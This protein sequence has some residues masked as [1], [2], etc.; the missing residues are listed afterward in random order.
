LKETDGMKSCLD[1]VREVFMSN[2]YGRRNATHW[3]VLVPCVTFPQ[4]LRHSFLFFI[5][6]PPQ[7]WLRATS[8]CRFIGCRCWIWL[9]LYSNNLFWNNCLDFGIKNAE[10]KFTH[11]YICIAMSLSCAK[12][13]HFWRGGHWYIQ[14]RNQVQQIMPSLHKVN[15][16]MGAC[17][18]LHVWSAKVLMRFQWALI[19]W[20]YS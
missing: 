1:Q 17:V 11:S 15:T 12:F 6:L 10:I 4:D 14:A 8:L 5:P 2:V 3:L 13:Y 18:H 16:V 7:I 9:P 19:L 20:I